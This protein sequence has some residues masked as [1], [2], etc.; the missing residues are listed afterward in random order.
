MIRICKENTMKIVSHSSLPFIS[1]IVVFWLKILSWNKRAFKYLYFRYYMKAYEIFVFRVNVSMLMW[2]AVMTKNLKLAFYMVARL[3]FL[4]ES[5]ATHSS[6]L[7][8]ET[9]WTEEPGWLGSI[10][11][12]RV[13]HNCSN[14]ARMHVLLYLK[15]KLK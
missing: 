9:P 2:S 6:T 3:H 14:L 5:M 7:A 10:G 8:W 12:Q 13:R 1:I 4:E 15:E 11:S